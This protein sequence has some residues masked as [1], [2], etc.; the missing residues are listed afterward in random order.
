MFISAFPFLAMYSPKLFGIN[1]FQ[2]LTVI[3]G[4]I[5]FFRIFSGYKV[6]HTYCYLAAVILYILILGALSIQFSDYGFIDSLE[7]PVK[8]LYFLASYEII[9]KIDISTNCKIISILIILPLIIN[10]FC[11]FNENFYELIRNIWNINSSSTWRFG[12]IFG[13]D[14]NTFGMYSTLTVIFFS[15]LL[16]AGLISRL[17][18]YLAVLFAIFSILI[19]GMRVGLYAIIISSL[20][21]INYSLYKRYLLKILLLILVIYFIIREQDSEIISNIF[22]RFSLDYLSNDLDPSGSGNLNTAINHFYEINTSSFSLF[23]IIF[24]INPALIYVDNIYIELFLKYGLIIIFPLFFLII[25]LLFN[26]FNNKKLLFFII[27]TLIVG[28][29]GAFP[30]AIYYITF[31]ALFI[32]ISY[33]YKKL[34]IERANIK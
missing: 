29:K 34:N 32:K 12:G 27:F 33:S 26:N 10:L 3:I 20:F 23:E 28:L 25:F 18:F 11:F 7:V 5:S 17:Y 31:T 2:I 6:L 1:P 8:L 24:G 30:L 16:N 21:F 14:V 19:S 9:R 15:M 22:N 13:E 4:G